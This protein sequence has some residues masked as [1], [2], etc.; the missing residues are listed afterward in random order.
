MH[1][2]I[3]DGKPVPWTVS[4]ALFMRLGKYCLTTRTAKKLKAAGRKTQKENL[5]KPVVFFL[6]P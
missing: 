2:V 4:S 3:Y 1:L 5:P 6:L